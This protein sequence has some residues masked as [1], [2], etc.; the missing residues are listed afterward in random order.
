MVSLGAASWLL[1]LAGAVLLDESQRPVRA[2]LQAGHHRRVNEVAINRVLDQELALAVIHSH[3][4]EGITG[5][6][7]P[8]GT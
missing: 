5:G 7:R 1:R 4:P 3:G 8:A 6:S 2:L